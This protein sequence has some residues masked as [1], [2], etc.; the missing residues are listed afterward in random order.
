MPGTQ[1]WFNMHRWNDVIYHVNE[2]KNQDHI[3]ITVN[4]EKPF[5][6]IQH[7]FVIKLFKKM[8]QKEH[9]STQ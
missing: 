5:D 3:R 1:A 7:T 8:V 6:K 9:T 2:M 4:A